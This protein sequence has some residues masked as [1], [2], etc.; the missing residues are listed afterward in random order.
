MR[1]RIF[2]LFISMVVLT[3]LIIG[4][5]SVPQEK[6]DEAKAALEAAKNAE[7]DRYVPDS[8]NAAKNALDGAM[9]EVNEQDSKLMFKS[10]DDAVTMLDNS[11]N[12]SKQAQQAAAD[13]KEA[14][15]QELPLL[16]EQFEEALKQVKTLMR[17]APRSKESLMALQSIQNDLDNLQNIPASANNAM[18][19]G[20]YIGAYNSVKGGMDR[21]NALIN[22]LNRAIQS[23]Y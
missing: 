9:A 10:F 15:R 11:I 8:Y 4:C 17:R 21:A 1:M 22:E 3:G 23:G 6:V 19:N 16:M 2:L 13:R 18:Q 12:L 20:D 14:V 7:A 5:G